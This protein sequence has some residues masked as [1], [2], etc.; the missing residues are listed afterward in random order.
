MAA[1]YFGVAEL[2]LMPDEAKA[3]AQAIAEVNR[4]YKVPGL[5]PA[6]AAIVSLIIVIGG[7]YG[8]RVPYIMAARK[9]YRSTPA[10]IQA[11]PEPAQEAA[12]PEP[13]AF[14]PSVNDAW[15]PPPST[16]N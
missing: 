9:G 10:P 7:T 2:Q 15:F 3:I 4:H 14:T 12:P 16:V 8:K 13:P 1:M 11:P 6:H 5:N